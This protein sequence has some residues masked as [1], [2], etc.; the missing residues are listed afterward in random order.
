MAQKKRGKKNNPKPN[1]K[2]FWI[3]LIGFFTISLLTI[4]ITSQVNLTGNTTVQPISF[5]KAGSE[6]TIEPNVNGVKYIQLKII[7]DLKNAQVITEEV[8]KISWDFQGTSI[9]KFKISSTDEDKLNL[10]EITLKFKEAQLD[11]IAKD[12]L[13]L[14]QEGKEL[15]TTLDKI[16]GEF[17][18]YTAQTEGMGEFVIGKMEK[19]AVADVIE[20]E[21]IP[22]PKAQLEELP[23][24]VEEESTPE[25][26]EV[27][28]KSFWEKI[29]NFFKNIFS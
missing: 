25:P 9:S 24:L 10:Y 18:F 2:T 7:E 29:A 21:V 14:Y 15:L 12:E 16:E 3:V 8:E 20:P 6:L 23:A 22:E 26:T 4:L 5:M 17:I 27:E 11:G 1:N 13:R 19:E 28:E